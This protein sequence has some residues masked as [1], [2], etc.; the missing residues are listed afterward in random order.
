MQPTHIFTNGCSFLTQRPKEGVMTHVGMELAKLMELET[1]LHLGGGGRGNESSWSAWAGSA[2]AVGDW[3]QQ[4][5]SNTGQPLKFSR[6]ASRSNSVASE[7]ERNA[8]Q[9][10]AKSAAS[11]AAY[12][13]AMKKNRLGG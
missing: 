12:H 2:D 7:P 9:P 13:R 10:K 11:L 1:A 3:R 6:N 8:R 5:W 4:S